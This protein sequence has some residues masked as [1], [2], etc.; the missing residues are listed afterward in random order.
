MIRAIV[1]HQPSGAVLS[2]A[3][4][5]LLLAV[6]MAT[7]GSLGLATVASADVPRIQAGRV[8]VEADRILT[9]SQLIF[10]VFMGAPDDGSGRLF[11]LEKGIPFT[12]PVPEEPPLGFAARIRIF[13]NGSLSTFLDLSAEVNSNSDSGL[14]GLAFHPGFADSNSLGYRKLYTYHSGFIDPNANVDFVDSSGL[15]T[16]HHNI[17]TEWQ[18]DANNPN[19]VDVST[20]R[21]LFRTTFVGVDHNS[22]AI[23]FGPDGYLYGT[24]GTPFLGGTT[25]LLTAQDNSD[26]LG[27]M[28]RIDPLAPSLTSGSA[29]PISGNGKYRIP[30]DNP[31]VDDP[32]ALSEIYAY[33]LRNTFRFSIDPVSGL[34]FGGDVGQSEREELNV[35]PKGGNMGWPYREGET[36]GPV[37]LPPPPLPAF[38]EPLAQYTHADGAAIVGGYVYHGSIAALQNKYIFGDFSKSFFSGAGRL[39]VAD[40]FDDL[41]QLKAPEDVEV[42]ELLFAP[43]SCAESLGDNPNCTFDYTLTSFGLDANGEL[44]AI[45]FRPNTSIIYKITDAYLLSEGDYNED[46]IVDAADYS[47]WRNTFGQSVLFGTKA[48]GNGSGM[49]DAGD[50]HVWKTHFGETVA[51]GSASSSPINVP[52]PHSFILAFQI[53]LGVLIS[54]RQAPWKRRSEMAAATHKWLGFFSTSRRS[55]FPHLQVS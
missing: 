31:F 3:I 26:L 2:C 7:F 53:L 50:Y 48:D 47:V 43:Q 49:I 37:P 27:S 44:Y 13:S 28:Y 19:V 21:E 36:N 6:F 29:N 42:Q 15:P 17:V 10:P 46:G 1:C 22:G 12:D 23:S 54:I 18:V 34:V 55:R 41:G 9:S 38:V 30:A 5:K 25:A 39:L 52:G 35:I 14:L 33:G 11:F 32:S 8:R 4:R 40:V 51:F 24:I 20:R 45:G 16:D